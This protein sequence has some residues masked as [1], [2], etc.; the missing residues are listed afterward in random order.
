M[1]TIDFNFDNVGGMAHLYLLEAAAISAIN[2][3]V[4]SGKV[5]PVLENGATIYNI[6]VYGGDSFV[7]SEVMSVEDSGDV[8]NVAISGFIPKLD[9]LV[10]IA[11]LEKGEWLALHQDANGNIILS[12]T[13]D[14]PLR[15][16]SSKSTGSGSAKNATAFTLQAKEPSPS[17]MAESAALEFS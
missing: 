1:K 2:T 3:N 8:F 15:F 14:V 6:I 5:L 10:D 12:G 17:M 7:F 16:L 9:N 13:R 4:S 11:K